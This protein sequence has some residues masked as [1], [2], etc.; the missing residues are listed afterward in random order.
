MLALPE[1]LIAIGAA[2]AAGGIVYA[3][4]ALER[5]RREAYEHYSLT[6]GFTFERERPEAHRRFETVFDLFAKGRSRKW[7]YTIAGKRNGY[8]FTAFEYAWV[9]SGGKNSQRH[10]LRGIVWETP[11]GPSAPTLPQF[12]IAP[13]GPLARL[14]HLLGRQDIDFAE[15]PDFSRAYQVRGPDEAAVR[16]LLTSEIRSFLV[17]TP[18]QKVTGG[19]SYLLWWD[20]GRLPRADLLDEWLEAG[21]RVRRLFLRP[22]SP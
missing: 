2:A 7:G 6:R 13:E 22:V 10:H 16:G 18:R 21:D 5:K 8:P 9:T 15:S 1:V 12:S 17:A 19:G 4:R 14:G 3:V 11:A 20:M